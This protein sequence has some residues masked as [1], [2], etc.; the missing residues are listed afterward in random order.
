MKLINKLI[1]PLTALLLVGCNNTVPT[2]LTPSGDGEPSNPSGEQGGGGEVT[3]PEEEETDESRI[4][5][6]TLNKTELILK[7]GKSDELIV[8]FFASDPNDDLEDAKDGEWVTSDS[9]VA[10]VRYGRVVAVK[11]GK[12]TVSYVT[13]EGNR[14]AS[15]TVYVVTSD[16]SIR[17]EYQRVDDLESLKQD[18]VIVF[19]CP[20]KGL[21]ATINRKDGYLIP[22]ESSFSSDKSRI[23]MMGIDTAEFLLTDGEEGG[24][25]MFAQNNQFLAA[26]YLKNI[27]FVNSKGALEWA[28]EYIDDQPGVSVGNYVYSTSSSIEGWLMFNTK[29]DRFT[30]YDS[31]VQVDMCLPTIYRETII[32]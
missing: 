11:E 17:K 32:L 22:I 1:L 5:H 4:D 6:I 20:E 28:F 14:R 19:A 2:D 9:S 13:V 18:D 16:A 31:S 7:V 3:P 26:K 8:N 24:F 23:T 10:T 27:T 21:T 29:A 25:T 15:C 12:A 30:L